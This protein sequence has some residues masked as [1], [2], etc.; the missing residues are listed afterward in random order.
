LPVVRAPVARL[1]APPLFA[2]AVPIWFAPSNTFTVLFASAIPVRFRPPL[3]LFVGVAIVGAVGAVVSILTAS[4][5][6]AALVP[7]AVVAVALRLWLPSDSAAV[8]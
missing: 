1:H 6:D 4:A 2:V 8:A 7:D 5:D 3:A